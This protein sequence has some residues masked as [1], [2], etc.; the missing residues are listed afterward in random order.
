M[1]HQ[2]IK[3]RDFLKWSGIA[4][5]AA[6][7]APSLLVGCSP[8]QE[9]LSQTSDAPDTSGYIMDAVSDGLPYGADKI[10]PVMCT[11]G[12]ACGQLHCG[13]A[14]VKDGAIIHYE[15]S[16]DAFN[17]GAMC[18]RGM[19]GF[20]IINHPDRIKY[21]MRRTNEK[22]VVGEFDASAGRR[23]WT[24]SLPQQ[25]RQYGRKGLTLLLPVGPIREASHSYPAPRFSTSSSDPISLC[26]P[27]VGST[28]SS[29]LFPLLATCITLSKKTLTNLR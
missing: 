28:F 15:G 1:Q 21:P 29:A 17:K 6:M 23:P 19:S 13:A 3:R 4:G 26:F 9:P 7:L 10:C 12:D 5:G 27:I 14:Y 18:A 8:Q 11:N 20:D 2:S 22:G 16:C 25:Q 24:R